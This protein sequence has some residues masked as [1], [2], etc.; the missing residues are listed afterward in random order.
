MAVLDLFVFYFQNILG[1][2]VS[3]PGNNYF[4][5]WDVYSL[6]KRIWV[7]SITRLS[8]GPMRVL[9]ILCRNPDS[10]PRGQVVK[11]ANL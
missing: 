6:K 8:M 7:V 5:V 10:C 2:L 9:C 11:V 1:N 4:L 3:F